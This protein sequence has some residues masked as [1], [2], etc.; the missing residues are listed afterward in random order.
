MTLLIFS[1]MPIFAVGLI[2]KHLSWHAAVKPVWAFSN[3]WHV[4]VNSGVK[5]T[6]HGMGMHDMVRHD[7]GMHDIDVHVVAMHYVAVHNVGL[8][9]ITMPSMDVYETLTFSSGKK[10]IFDA[11]LGEKRQFFPIICR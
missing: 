6:M 1:D 10:L 11:H 8:P 3:S 4:A 5:E 7:V 9:G 2:L